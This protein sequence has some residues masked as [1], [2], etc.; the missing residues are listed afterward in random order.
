MPVAG[1][2]TTVSS[3]PPVSLV[4][5]ELDGRR[6]ALPIA[7]VI[8]VLRMVAITPLPDSP[9]WVAGVI[10]VRGDIVPVIDLRTRLGVEARGYGLD[11]P[12]LLVSAC[13]RR[14]AVVPDAAVE[15]RDVPSADLEDPDDLVGDEHPISHI[16]RIEGRVVPVLL[17]DQICDGAQT[18]ALPADDLSAA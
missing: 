5:L 12:I 6:L 2:E 14:M 16:A 11:T 15:V 10:N 4:V 3:A 13:G 8:E 9:D 17:L 18:L 1:S 7:R